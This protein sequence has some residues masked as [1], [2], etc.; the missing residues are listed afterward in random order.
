M[1][2]WLGS[3][4][5]IARATVL[6]YLSETIVRK[7]ASSLALADVGAGNGTAAPTADHDEIVVSQ[8]ALRAERLW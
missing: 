2:R 6:W 5:R 4:T 8:A 1:M 7:S 3:A